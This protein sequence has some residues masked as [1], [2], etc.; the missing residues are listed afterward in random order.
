MNFIEQNIKSDLKTLD[1]GCGKDKI[2]NS[3]GIDKIKSESVDVRHDLNNF[4]Y[5]FDDDSFELVVCKHS[6][7]HIDNFEKTIF[8]IFRILKPGGKLLIIAPHFSSDNSFTD[9]TIKHFFGYRTLDYFINDNSV[10]S[11][12]YSFYSNI[13]FSMINRRIFMYKSI[14]KNF[15]DRI[16]SLF[17]LPLDIIINSFPRFYE[18]FLCFIIRAN[19]VVFLLQKK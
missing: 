18:K 11:K 5:P 15:I 10:L 16:I 12:K 9:Y 7:S 3:I 1:L 19:E 17:F 13:K 6:I 4:P 2:E 8:E 14:R